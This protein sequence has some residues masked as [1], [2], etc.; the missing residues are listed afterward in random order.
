MIEVL[1]RLTA[2]GMVVAKEVVILLSNGLADGAMRSWRT[3]YEISVVSNFILTHGN[4]VAA[5]FRDYHIVESYNNVREYSKHYQQLGWAKPSQKDLN[6]I[7]NEYKQV[8]KTYGENYGDI[9]GWAR[10]IFKTGKIT[11][12]RIESETKL[13]Y[14]RPLYLMSNTEVHASSKA[15]YLRMG[16]DYELSPLILAGSS[17]LG[18]GEPGRRTAHSATLLVGV[19]LGCK[20][21]LETQAYA[22]SFINLRD[23]I[24]DAFYEAEYKLDQNKGI[25]GW[26]S[27]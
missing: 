27:P 9:N 23:R 17:P 16:L 2:R 6:T 11:F 20:P 7:E 13:E 21:T 24:F 3:L 15:L 10:N 12:T 14:L 19:L 26:T 1:T 5:R 25:F 4:D 18:L 22:K 8:L